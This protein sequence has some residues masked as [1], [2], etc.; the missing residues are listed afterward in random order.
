M[1]YIMPK[2]K[3]KKVEPEPEPELVL[4][5]EHECACYSPETCTGDCPAVEEIVLVKPE[6]E[7]EPEKPRILRPCERV[8]T[9]DDLERR[10]QNRLLRDSQRAEYLKANPL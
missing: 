10:R 2:K 9:A 3:S 7:P 6:P 4:E 1:I 5:P 8:R